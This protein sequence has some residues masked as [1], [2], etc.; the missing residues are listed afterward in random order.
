MPLPAHLFR[1]PALTLAVL[2][3]LSGGL[4]TAFLGSSY[5]KAPHPGIYMVLTGVWFGLVIGFAVWRWSK[6]SWPAVAMAVAAT[7]I[8][9]EAAVNLALQLDGP[10]LEASP[11][12]GTASKAYIAG[13]AA[14]AVGALATWAGVAAFTPMLRRASAAALIVATGAVFGLLLPWTNNYDSGAVLLLPWQAAVAA[15]I[16]YY[17]RPAHAPALHDS[18]AVAIGG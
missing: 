7:W 17:M 11:I 16:G 13:F 10:W 15:A 6:R 2:G 3:L 1:S 8:G 18:G 12:T 4:G 9:W 5:G 14:G